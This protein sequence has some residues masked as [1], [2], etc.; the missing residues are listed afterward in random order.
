MEP[1]QLV[2][3]FQDTDEMVGPDRPGHFGLMAEKADF[4][5]PGQHRVGLDCV[6]QHR[7]RLP[8]V[9]RALTAACPAQQGDR[10]IETP[11]G[12]PAVRVE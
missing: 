8:V 2:I 9:V 10:V 5:R 6:L 3:G 7:E 4:H 11:V 12:V 1:D